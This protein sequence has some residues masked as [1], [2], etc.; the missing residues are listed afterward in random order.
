MSNMVRHGKNERKEKKKMSNCKKKNSCP[1]NTVI[2]LVSTPVF[3]GFGGPGV[4]SLA[5][6]HPAEGPKKSS[7]DIPPSHGSRK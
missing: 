1:G 3:W 4:N 2:T 7:N 6:C 5:T